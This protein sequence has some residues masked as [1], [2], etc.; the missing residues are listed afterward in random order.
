MNMFIV[1]DR[2]RAIY[3]RYH[4]HGML[5]DSLLLIFLFTRF[6]ILIKLLLDSFSEQVVTKK[7]V[8]KMLKTKFN[9]MTN[10]RHIFRLNTLTLVTLI[11]IIPIV[12]FSMLMQEFES[13]FM[14]SLVDI[15]WYI[16]ITMTTVGYGDMYSRNFFSN[17]SMIVA[18]FL[19]AICS[20]MYITG[21]YKMFHFE[22]N[23]HKAFIFINRLKTKEQLKKEVAIWF[24][25]EAKQRLLYKHNPS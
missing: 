9:S 11:F 16:V 10:L 24:A 25:C 3:S 5:N 19:G 6:V 7:R 1:T 18:I 8:H 21:I 23:E 14:S 2:M 17:L 12:C 13:F 20:A 15:L 4:Y 22:S